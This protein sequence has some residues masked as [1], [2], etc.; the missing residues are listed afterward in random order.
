MKFSEIPSSFKEEKLSEKVLQLKIFIEEK[1]KGKIEFVFNNE[2][3][4]DAGTYLITFDMKKNE[5]S[6]GFHVNC[7]P[8]NAAYISKTLSAFLSAKGINF[9]IRECIAFEFNKT[10]KFNKRGII[11]SIITGSDAFDTVDRERFWGDENILFM[12]VPIPG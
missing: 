2:I 8:C 7:D 1:L 4:V 9:V 5:F 12:D 6:I 10:S 11:S 3:L